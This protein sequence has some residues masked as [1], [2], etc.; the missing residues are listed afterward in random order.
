LILLDTS[1]LLA[2]MFAD[3]TDHPA[4]REALEQARPPLILSPFVLAELDFLVLRNA[5]VDAELQLLEEVADGAYDLAPF[6]QLDVARALEIATL[7]VNS[8]GWRYRSTKNRAQHPPPP[9]A[10]QRDG[11]ADDLALRQLQLGCRGQR[12]AQHGDEDH[13]HRQRRAE[14]RQPA[15]DPGRQRRRRPGHRV[16]VRELG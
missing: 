5:G 15:P 6:S 4:C 1:G 14:R 9:H 3:Q 10:V 13:H 11:P 2:A 8:S 7:P 12:D 16:S